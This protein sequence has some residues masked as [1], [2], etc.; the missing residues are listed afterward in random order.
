MVPID[1]VRGIGYHPGEMNNEERTHR[2]AMMGVVAYVEER[3]AD[4]QTKNG[5]QLP[6]ICTLGKLEWEEIMGC[7]IDEDFSVGGVACV[8]DLTKPAGA[9]LR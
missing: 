2:Y 5:G 1:I 6:T 4:F 8:P 3:I 7:T 9:N